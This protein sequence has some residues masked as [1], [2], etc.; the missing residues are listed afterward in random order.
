MDS[1]LPPNPYKALNVAQ[2]APLATIR[3][4]HRKLVLTCHPDKF[5]DEAVKVQKQ[6]QFHQVQQ[7]YEILS[8]ETKRQQYDERVKLAELRAE[9]MKEKGGSRLPPEYASR[10]VPEFS[11]RPRPSPMYEMRGEQVYEERV[12]NRAYEEDVFSTTFQKHRPAQRNYDDRYSP[13]TSRRSS[14]RVAEERRRSRDDEPRYVYTRQSAKAAEKSIKHNLEEKKRKDKDKRKDR[15][16]KFTSKSPYVEEYES[17][18]DAT[19]R[20][21]IKATPR[22]RHDD[23]RRRDRDEPR[24]TSGRESSDH[25]GKLEKKTQSAEDYMNQKR[26]AA[27]IEMET[28]RPSANRKFSTTDF[29]TRAA[30]SS[31]PPMTPVDSGR[32]SGRPREARKVSPIRRR[33]TESVDPPRRPSMPGPSE[34]WPPKN[35]IHPKKE[36]SRASTMPITPDSRHPGM[37][38][39][40]T[41]PIS[42]PPRRS[43][44]YPTK[45]KAKNPDIND[46]GYSSPD[47]PEQF[48]GPIPPLRRMKTYQVS[49]DDDGTRIHNIIYVEPDEALNRHDRDRERD[50]SPPRRRQTDRPVMAARPSSNARSSLQHSSTFSFPSDSAQSS[51]APPFAR[52]ESNRIPSL[53][54]RHSSRGSHQ[55]Y[56]EILQ[57]DEP[58][59][60]V[61]ESPRFRPSDISYS[62]RSPEELYRDTVPG[63][64]FDARHRPHLARNEKAY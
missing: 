59:K 18:S 52:A 45:P 4:A 30:Y 15:E 50:S 40:D 42:P 35:M 20:I 5:Q 27:P 29:E 36:P 58:Y 11:A 8:D 31:A 7:A 48:A 14:T 25:S 26:E 23:I 2:D 44:T 17:D 16:A 22:H 28:R 6:E 55:L 49:Q 1:P 43:E 53:H 10:V 39:S 3:S 37:R 46:S 63:S 12:P 56:G 21:Y 62:R 34:P 61:N 54:S 38:R 24:R 33:M 41:T 51:R 13:P 19:E 60:V 57:T 47:T 32:R 64:H 9:M